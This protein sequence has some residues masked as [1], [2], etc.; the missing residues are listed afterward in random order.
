MH[1]LS[2]LRSGAP[3]LV[4]FEL[5]D[6]LELGRM[7]LKVL[8][9]EVGDWRFKIENMETFQQEILLT[10]NIKPLGRYFHL[11]GQELEL[12]EGRKF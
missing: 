9:L 11:N 8:L 10:I 5:V 1:F 2:G 3:N 6:I 7:E 4:E 12:K